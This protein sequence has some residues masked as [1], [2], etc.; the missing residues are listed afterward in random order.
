LVTKLGGEPGVPLAMKA[1]LVA[2]GTLGDQAD[3]F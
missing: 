2:F 1:W 3:P